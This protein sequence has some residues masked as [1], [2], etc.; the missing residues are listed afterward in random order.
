MN[1]DWI[2]TL[3]RAEVRKIVLFNA[4]AV[5]ILLLVNLFLNPMFFWFPLLTLIFEFFCCL[6][7]RLRWLCRLFGASSSKS[8]ETD[9]CIHCSLLQVNQGFARSHGLLSGVNSPLLS[10]HIAFDSNYWPIWKLWKTRNAIAMKCN[11]VL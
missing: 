8:S 10:F 7:R 3:L 4:V 1:F 6:W 9:T 11:D 2:L 5:T